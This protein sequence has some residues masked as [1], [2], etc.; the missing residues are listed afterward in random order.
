MIVHA[1]NHEAELLQVLPFTYLSVQKH[2]PNHHLVAFSDKPD[3]AR[4]WFGQRRR[5]SGET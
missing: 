3:N 1:P 5:P 2:R 4:P